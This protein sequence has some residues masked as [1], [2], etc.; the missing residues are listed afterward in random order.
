MSLQQPKLDE[1]RLSMG[2]DGV[3]YK[4]LDP[5]DW[6]KY[7]ILSDAELKTEA[8]RSQEVKQNLLTISGK[9]A[10]GGTHR[11]AMRSGFIK[12]VAPQV[13]TA[14]ASRRKENKQWTK[15]L[16]KATAGY[17]TQN[18]DEK[19]RATMTL[20]QQNSEL[21]QEEVKGDF[22][23]VVDNALQGDKISKVF[24]VI[25]QKYE[26]NLH[27]IDKLYDE[28]LSLEQY[29]RSLEE[30]L[31]EVTGRDLDELGLQANGEADLPPDYDEFENVSANMAATYAAPPRGSTGLTAGQAAQQLAQ[32]KS[33]LEAP[34]YSA[35]EPRGRSRNR[36]PLSASMRSQSLNRS[37]A[38]TRS[39]SSSRR[40][41]SL[42]R[43]VSP[44]LQ[45]DI[46]NYVQKQRLFEEKE[47]RERLEK[48]AEEE[49]RR[50]KLLMASRNGNPFIAMHE[51]E[52]TMHEKKEA[53]LAALRQE[54]EKKLR[55]EKLKLEAKKHAES[56]LMATAIKGSMSWQ[57]LQDLEEAKRRERIESRKQ[58]LQ[59]ISALPSALAE[60]M[61]RVKRVSTVA[62]SEPMKSNFKAED[63]EVVARRLETQQKTWMTRLEQ[64]KEKLRE[65]FLIRRGESG[66]LQGSLTK[67]MELRAD[68]AKQKRQARLQS[69]Y[70]REMQEKKRQE[71]LEEEKKARLL[72]MSLPESSLK[73][74]K[75]AAMREKRVKDGLLDK[76]LERER[77]RRKMEQKEIRLKETAVVLKSVMRDRDE[78][79]KAKNPGMKLEVSL[80]EHEA[81][82][83]AARAREEYRAK[84]RENKQK[85]KEAMRSRPSL[86]ERHDQN[87]A[88]R[89]AATQAL[90]TIT[91]AMMGERNEMDDLEDM[92]NKKS[93]S[94]S[95]KSSG[96]SATAALDT[97]LK[98]DE[99][100]NAKEK[101]IVK[102][103]LET[104]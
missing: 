72:N 39:L 43:G 46:D 8:M 61:Q 34:G 64:H 69:Q 100:F 87:I 16:V 67:S 29:A 104:A 84:L 48:E 53:K 9:T 74:T 38:P 102:S 96:K 83:R 60:S 49:R 30:K 21:P 78:E 56:Q 36:P 1:T 81:V 103:L 11:H 98:D 25:K 6:S 86:L 2:N 41:L 23:F 68:H 24:R 101:V 5:E 26:Q 62:S 20:L 10:Y 79:L 33:P 95:R 63:P 94:S 22:E 47:R 37:S 44:Q 66:M 73:L 17:S 28:R 59:R 15:D 7:Q 35:T 42:G 80:A 99:I 12:L 19:H 52:K 91:H 55:E 82:E 18:M 3:L 89:N 58:D 50:E 85:L 93:N 77:E 32:S 92:L 4:M 57:E 65:D 75:A 13:G 51:R 27:V 97:I 40:S 90:K 88:T 31:V 45:A 76:R 14:S 71:E 54:E 70:E